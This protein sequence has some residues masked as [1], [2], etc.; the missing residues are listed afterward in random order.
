MST[1]AVTA[2]SPADRP[3]GERGARGRLAASLIVGATLALAL[4][5]L[6]SNGS[7]SGGAGVS[8]WQIAYSYQSPGWS[9][10]G[11]VTSAA[12]LTAAG[13]M[14]WVARSRRV[15]ALAA[16]VAIAGAGTLGWT[17]ATPNT[18]RISP[19]TYRSIGL[20][21]TQAEITGRLGAPFSTDASATRSRGG[22]SIGCLLYRASVSAAA[23]TIAVNG[24][25]GGFYLPPAV[26]THGAPPYVAQPNVTGVGA[27]T[28]LFCFD[29]GLLRVKS[30]I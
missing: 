21:M 23:A 22:A 14:L 7:G 18:I 4:I 29:H 30:A 26:T 9:T 20:G 5:R 13:T 10:F 6:R 19:A 27:S 16:A 12:C 17:I 1:R 15:I 11:F 25:S 3:P 28:Y 8:D 2:T 24:G